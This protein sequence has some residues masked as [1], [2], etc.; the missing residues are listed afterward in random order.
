MRSDGTHVPDHE[1]DPAHNLEEG[2]EWTDEGGASHLGPATHLES[3]HPGRDEAAGE[4]ERETEVEAEPDHD[5]D[6][7]RTPGRGWV[8]EGGASH[9]GP[10]TSLSSG[11][12]DEERAE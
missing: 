7:A 1:S 5:S 8:G 9:L 11:R 10:A 6:P 3:G 4:A 2:H 12:P